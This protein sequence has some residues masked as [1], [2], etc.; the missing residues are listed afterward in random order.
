M[1]HRCLYVNEI[2]AYTSLPLVHDAVQTSP[3]AIV[4][5]QYLAMYL[6][7]DISK[8]CACR[9]YRG[10]RGDFGGIGE[11]CLKNVRKTEV[12]IHPRRKR[13]GK[14]EKGKGEGEGCALARE[15]F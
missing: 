4:C 14:G 5:K 12:V 10:F 9:Y 7:R 11:C 13:R 2:R 8:P 15:Y 3:T 1:V 6:S